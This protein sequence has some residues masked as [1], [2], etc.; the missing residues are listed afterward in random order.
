M[1]TAQ[2]VLAVYLLVVGLAV[3]VNFVAT[4]FYHEGGDDYPVWDVLNWFMA[5][6]M[7][8]AVVASFIEKRRSCQAGDDLK[9]HVDANVV[10]YAAV[11]V[12]LLFLANWG[13]NLAD[14]DS[15]SGDVWFMVDAAMPVLLGVVGMRL[16][17]GAGDSSAQ[18]R[19]Q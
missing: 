18:A 19:G 1:N 15:R 10:F 16:W 6:A 4:P 12:L 2:R 9:R 13:A 7:V 3:A 14:H 8:I 5:A 11:V 17:R